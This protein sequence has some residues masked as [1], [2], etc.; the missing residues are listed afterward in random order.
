LVSIVS[1]HSFAFKERKGVR[2]KFKTMLAMLVVFALLMAACG[3]QQTNVPTATTAPTEVSTEP[4]T[5][6]PSETETAEGSPT[7]E[8]TATEAA[9]A[10]A[11]IPVTGGVTVAVSESTEFGSYLVDGNGMSLYLFMADTQDSGTST[12]GDDDGCTEE[13]PPLLCPAEGTG[14]G[15]D[16]ANAN[17]NANT[18]DNANANTNT[19]A[20]DNTNTNTNTNTNANDNA[21]ANANANDNTNTSGTPAAADCSPEAMAGDGVDATLLGTITRD[22]GTTQVTYNGWPL[23]FFHEDTAAGDTNGQ[24]IDEFG[25]LWYLVLPTGEAITQ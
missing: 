22:D 16:N 8:A 25:G 7:A 11:G 4:A 18:N 15:N 19:N 20:N 23:Y 6:E 10:T 2:M 1:K 21:N 14:L 24:G 17:A 12:C 5:T 9:T 13:W 3:P